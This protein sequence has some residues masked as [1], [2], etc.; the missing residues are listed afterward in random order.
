[1]ETVIVICLLIVIGLLLE[2]KIVIRKGEEQK[3]IQEKTNP[4]L[5]DIM[6]Q[7]K[8]MRS[9]SV[10]ISAT[11]RQNKNQ[12]QE[13]DNFDIE[14][15]EEDVDI[16]IPQEELDKVFGNIADLEEEEEEWNRYGISSGDNGF[17][18]GVTFEE[19]SSVGM[20]LQKEKLEPSQKE[21]AVAIVQKIQGT[22]LFTLLE[23]SM[24]S[25][26]RKI[27]ELLDGS[28]FSETDAGSFFLRKNDFEDFDIG[29]FV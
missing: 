14:I 17:A 3:P 15:D 25:A 22:E 27:A 18:Q 4:N 12:E 10:P 26:S 5:P 29:E 16:Q 7:P 19:L 13:T 23:N 24:E 11:E 6:G 20:L 1:M 21:T 9:L 28:L 2:D 8:P